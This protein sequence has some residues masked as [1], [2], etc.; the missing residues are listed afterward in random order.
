MTSR[1]AYGQNLADCFRIDRAPSFVSRTLRHSEIAVTQITCDVENNGLSALIPR[2]DAFLVTLQLRDCPAHDLWL[3]GRA[4]K[5]EPLTAGTT[6]VYD[7]RRSPVVNSIS[8]FRN[9]HF[10][11]SRTALDA[12]AEGDGT[13]MLDALPHNPGVGM[14]D[15]VIRSLGSSL[16]PAFE[17]PDEVTTIF[18]DHITTAAAAYVSHLFVGPRVSPPTNGLTH[19]QEQRA[20]EMLRARLDGVLSVAQLA[21]ECGL[22]SRAFS[23]AFRKST[24]RLPHRWLLEQRVERAKDLLRSRR[25]LEEI[26]AACG[27]A[28]REH[29]KRVFSQMV[30]TS[31]EQ[32]RRFT[33]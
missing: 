4:M 25:S 33:G 13:S 11:F 9:L 30:G 22:S 31:P 10:Y 19:W 6:C 32:W 24:G 27:F 29:L 28:G 5:T 12:A 17:R 2:E 18:V 20:K 8:P 26:A 1:G 3:D 21:R 7:L 16:L 15:Q 14:D 23:S